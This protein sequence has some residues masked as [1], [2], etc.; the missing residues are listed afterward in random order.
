MP[1]ISP[2]SWKD[3]IK[4][5]LSLWFDIYR[6]TGSHHFMKHIDGRITVIPLHKNEDLWIWL[7]KKILRDINLSDSDF[8][9]VR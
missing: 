8:N 7:L 5:L 2:I 9:D 1:K 3:M 4:I 6:I